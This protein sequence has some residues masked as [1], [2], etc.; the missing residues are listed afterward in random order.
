MTI[1]AITKAI[2]SLIFLTGLF[3]F[4]LSC[5]N[6]I[7]RADSDRGPLVTQTGDCVGVQGVVLG[8]I[9][10]GSDV[11]LY[12]TGSPVYRDVMSKIKEGN[13]IRSSAV[14]S[15]KGFNFSCTYPGYYAFVIPTSSYNRSVG[16]PL[17]YEFDCEKFS[18]RISFQG[19]NPDYAVGAFW[20]N[21]TISNQNTRDMDIFSRIDKKGP[22]YRECALD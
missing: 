19:G 16:S 20:I 12:E 13:P 9:T 7:E 5:Q 14:N 6:Q 22:L 17:P 8:N 1:G 18:L 10:T 11:F 3:F 21:K 4:T 2:T 15:T